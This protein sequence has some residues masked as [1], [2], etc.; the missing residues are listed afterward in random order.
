M[1]SMNRSQLLTFLLSF[2]IYTLLLTFPVSAVAQ[3]FPDTTS[4]EQ[5]NNVP[6]IPEDSLSRRTPRGTVNGFI[7]A[8][9]DENYDRASRYLNLSSTGVEEGEELVRVVQRLL[10]RGGQIMPYSWISN[11]PEGQT[12]DD[13]PPGIDRIGT[14]TAEAETFD[15]FVEK[16]TGPED[17]PIWLLS[18]ETINKIQAL[19]IQDELLVEKFMPEFLLNRKWAGIAVGQWLFMFFLIIPAYFISWA[20]VW[21]FQFLLRLVWP[22][23]RTEPTQGIIKAFAL[24][25]RIYLAVWLFVILSQ[26]VGISILLRQRFSWI[27]LIL[28]IVALLI[29]LWRLADFISVFSQRK[30]S[31]QGKASLVSVILFLRRFAKIAIVVFGIIAILGAVG[32]DVTT[33]LAAL[34]I[35]GIA[36]ALGAQKTVENFVGSV[37]LIA[38]QPIRVGDFCK[39]GETIGTVESIGMRSTR[40]RTNDRT[41][42]TIPNGE[43][44]STRIENFAHRDRFLLHTVIGVRYETTPDQL[45]YLLVEIRAILYSHPMIDPNP[46]RVRFQGFGA[47]SLN[48]EIFTYF[49]AINFENYVELREDLLL[50]IMDVIARS[51]TEF[52][53]PSQ[54][55]YFA[56]DTGLSEEKAK[57]IEEVVKKWKENNEMEI[58]KFD[59]DKI[60]QIKNSIKYPPEGSSENKNNNPKE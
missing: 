43:F 56:K 7:K 44:S 29:L 47:S 21:L 18:S 49:N 40:I 27:T 16:T 2:F 45:R 5:V 12:N 6:E 51:G 50:R 39:V 14:V 17:A 54:T 20:I 1:I 30:M 23:A 57:E 3:I 53:F 41:V 28:G 9:A 11:D 60:Q 34:G 58:P 36:L 35:G 31:L 32:V 48:L 15:L 55:L 19:D 24:P 46:A 10:D 25:I 8:I 42:V 13:L 59:P 26:E 52:A 37:T 38:D 4:K 33:G 22:K